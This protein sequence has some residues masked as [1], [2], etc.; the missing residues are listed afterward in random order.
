MFYFSLDHRRVNPASWGD[1]GASPEGRLQ[2][3]P[4]WQDPH[5]DQPGHR[6]TRGTDLHCG[7]WVIEFV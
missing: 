4:H 1:N 5:S 2:R 7:L 3:R 6:R